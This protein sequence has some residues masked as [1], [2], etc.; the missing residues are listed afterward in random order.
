MVPDRLSFSAAES[1]SE[2]LRKRNLT[3]RTFWQPVPPQEVDCC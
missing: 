3:R 1:A 2:A